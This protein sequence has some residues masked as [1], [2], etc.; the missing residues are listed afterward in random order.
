MR[1]LV[2][3]DIPFARETFADFPDVREISGRH[4]SRSVIGDADVLVIRSITPVNSGLLE[5]TQVRFVG[6][7]TIGTDHIDMGYLRSR[8]IDFVI[9][10]LT[11]LSMRNRVPKTI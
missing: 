6:A 1:I 8:K 2:D 3:E 4:L 10:L 11:F 7:A 5:G 9:G